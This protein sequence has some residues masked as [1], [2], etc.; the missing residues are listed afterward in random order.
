M[1]LEG[2]GEE[3]GKEGA[4]GEGKNGRRSLSREKKVLKE[5]NE[6]MRKK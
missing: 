5:G 4:R 6:K 3:R 2:G 1:G